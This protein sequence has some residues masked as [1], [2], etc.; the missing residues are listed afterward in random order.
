MEVDLITMTCYACEIP[1]K[2]REEEEEERSILQYGV[3]YRLTG[4]E[5]A[6]SM[7]LQ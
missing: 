6:L 7:K 2:R 5:L 4:P 1:K 3:E